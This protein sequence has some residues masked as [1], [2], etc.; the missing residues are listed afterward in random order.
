MLGRHVSGLVQTLTILIADDQVATRHRESGY[1]RFV[2]GEDVVADTMLV[3]V[4]GGGW[5]L[6]TP[7]FARY[8]YVAGNNMG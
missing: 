4:G 6:I 7:T 3:C 1:G 2:L 5:S 8:Y